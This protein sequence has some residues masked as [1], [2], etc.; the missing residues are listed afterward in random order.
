MLVQ[1]LE[2]YKLIEANKYKFEERGLNGTFFIDVYRSQPVE[3][4]LYEY[5]SLPAIF[6]DYTM[7]GQGKNQ[8]RLISLTLHIVTD[9]MPDASNI[10]LQKD[11][12]L[13]R[14]LYHLILQ[15]ILE[16]SK[17]GR[18]KELKFINEG[19]IDEPVI[20]YHTQTYEFEAYLYDMFPDNIPAIFGEFERLNI[21]GSLRQKE[22]LKPHQIE[23]KKEQSNP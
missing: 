16:G 3:P 21:Y 12:G 4:E 9:E 8:P 11:E 6:A 22:L 13:K 20:N 7:Q 19:I 2:F 1:F 17:L 23:F 10:S 18:T 5:F 14:F 15:E